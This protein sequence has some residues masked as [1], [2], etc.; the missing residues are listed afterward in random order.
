MLP[1][2]LEIKNF[3]AY[4]SPDPVRFD[5]IHL[6]CLTG[7]NGAGKSS[8]LDA[9]TWALWGKAR[10]RRD[11]ELVHM[12]QTDM[13]VQLDF[14]QEGIVY[15]VIR[16]RTRRSGGQGT[17]DLFSI[18]EEGSRV[19]LNEPNMRATQA[20]IN[21]L[22]N[23]DYDTFTNS[24]FLQQGKAD[25]FTMKPAAE[26]K[27]IL[28]D[29]LNLNRWADY[30]EAAKAAI[31]AAN[32]S[33]NICTMRIKEIDI[34][35]ARE[36]QLKIALTEA[37]AAQQ[38]AETQL[39][40]AEA[41]LKEVEHAPN[42]LRAAREQCAGIETR[43]RNYAGDLA[44]VDGDIT[45]QQER[46]TAFERVLEEREQIQTGYAELQAARESDHVF[47]DKLRQWS[48]VE[49]RRHEIERQI[50]AA[51]AEIEREVRPCETNV[52]ALDKTIASAKPDD[53]AAVQAEV[54]ALEDLD[55]QRDL[56]DD[57]VSAATKES[58]DLK[59]ENKALYT[60]MNEIKAH[61]QRLSAVEGATCPYCG[62]PL[63]E[64]KRLEIISERQAE[65]ETLGDQWRGNKARVEALETIISER[66]KAVSEIRVEIRRLSALKE[67]AG[68]LNAGV[69]AALKAEIQREEVRA[70]LDQLRETLE[71][72]QF[73]ADLRGQLATL[74]A[75]RDELGYD[76]DEH[77]AVREKLDTY[78]VYETRQKELMIALEALPDATAAYE[79]ALARRERILQ[80]QAQEE[81][82][83][84]AERVRI[85]E[86]EALVKQHQERQLEVNRLRLAERQAYD[87][88][89]S[90][91]QDLNALDE[92]RRRRSDI[93]TDLYDLRERR[94]VYEELKLA[95]GKNG[96]PAMIIETAI[97]E[98]ESAA[99]RLLSRMTDGRMNLTMST[100][101]EKVTGGISETLDIQ[102][103]DELGTRAY[104][105]FSGGEAF[106]INFAIR[107]ALS[108]MLARRA[109]AHLR[110]LFI[111][112]GFGT[113]DDEGR[114]K[115]VE[116]ITAV[117]DDF[118]VI[119]VVTHIEELRDA[120]PVHLAIEKTTEGSTISV[121]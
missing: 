115:L 66:V 36:P 100:Q 12:G 91:R 109:G 119:I 67:R 98:L 24:A 96:I 33:I 37:E 116:A 9:I 74:I 84:E 94:A 76:S 121:R 16:R 51:R 88:L 78:S 112:E 21:R 32:E 46:I 73:A 29:I 97:P 28:V 113:Q 86:L 7:A 79:S 80:A 92:L 17:L 20:K 18:D 39:V 14:E 82:A 61:Q 43:L 44:A 56:F 105:L 77:S 31:S 38:A 1:I 102:I 118:D 70:R 89:S 4:R 54:A 64:S 25:A 22:L 59:A 3:L 40:D 62:Q 120:F 93:E 50:D 47:G 117:Q 65:G 13:Y 85:V 42:D 53:L 95:F 52:Q 81:V 10:A 75:R 48:D 49:A 55:A 41:R 114:N 68:Q 35:L 99:N 108:Q 58:A 27:R 11:E 15:S 83:L 90:A 103:A 101:R 106:R 72:E 5:G 34:E 23:L 2:R 6:A 107:V 63:E 71:Q 19:N 8:L 60:R 57:E 30:E 110:T 104:E 87:K 111:D 45:R 69:E 26:R